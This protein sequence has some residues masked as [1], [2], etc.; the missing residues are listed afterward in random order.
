MAFK[1]NLGTLGLNLSLNDRQFKSAMGGASRMI[2]S[3]GAMAA[4][5]AAAGVGALSAG[6]LYSVHSFAK[7]EQAIMNAV[8][9]SGDGIKAFGQFKAAAMDAAAGSMFSATEAGNALEFLSLAGLSSG[10][11]IAALPGVLQL[12]TAGQIELGQA[13]DIATDTLTA[14]GLTAGDLTRVNDVLVRTFTSSNTSLT[15]LGEAMSYVGP[16]ARSM[17]VDIET[18]AAALGLLGD[19]GIKGSEGGTMLRGVMLRL[20]APTDDA[21]GA[22][23]KLKVSVY[24]TDGTMRDL[25]GVFEDL[26]KATDDLAGEDVNA[27]MRDIFGVRNIAGAE[28]LNQAVRNA[29]KSFRGYRDS[30]YE[31][32]GEGARVERMMESTLS[33]SMKKLKGNVENLAIMFGQFFGPAIYDVATRLGDMIKRVATTDEGFEGMRSAAIHVLRTLAD[34]LDGAAS[35]VEVFGHIVGATLEAIN[36]FDSYTKMIK[37]TAATHD[38]IR[39]VFHGNAM[40][41]ASAYA[42][43]ASAQNVF[44]HSVKK[45]GGTYD[46]ATAGAKLAANGIRVIASASREGANAAAEM[47]HET[48]AQ[49]VVLDKMSKLEGGKKKRIGGAKKATPKDTAMEAAMGILGFGAGVAQ[50]AQKEH[51]AALEAANKA[52]KDDLINALDETLKGIKERAAIEKR[53]QRAAE[54]AAKVRLE[55]EEAHA[56]AYVESGEASADI[57]RHFTDK[58]LGVITS[59]FGPG[60][61]EFVGAMDSA[62]AIGKEVFDQTGSHVAAV[63]AGLADAALS[64]VGAIA[65]TDEFQDGMAAVNH[66]F[67]RLI[68]EVDPLGW[69]ASHLEGAFGAFIIAFEEI[70]EMFPEMGGMSSELAKAF[71]DAA[72]GLIWMMVGV[73]EVLNRISQGFNWLMAAIM[74]IP[75]FLADMINGILDFFGFDKIDTGGIDGVLAGFEEASAAAAAT[76]DKLGQIRDSIGEMTYTDATTAFNDEVTEMADNMSELNDE[77]RNAPSGFKTRLASMRYDAD[78]GV[79]VGSGGGGGSTTVNINALGMRASELIQSL[80]RR[81]ILRS[82]SSTVVESTRYSA[83]YAARRF[84]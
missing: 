29:D 78:D 33:G 53:A 24:D 8:A 34:F 51:A 43:M 72:R 82:G 19:V 75:K 20:A 56:Q 28:A 50:K 58:A 25:V 57:A 4:K 6:L 15:Q 21:R 1:L 70:A 9:V 11:S 61:E 73:G 30:M 47:T 64:L 41:Q 62:F 60:F 12:A 46:K 65:A 54:K 48:L 2:K 16:V 55:A 7:F 13:T 68:G 44:D 63:A 77:L 35:F 3:F 14:F 10:E 17:G 83:D 5:A 22:L 52:V 66:A 36:A 59:I 84:A 42:K 37:L 23:K 27:L 74:Q 76:A 40:E 69:L 81:S 80:E 67:E 39:N 49:Q 38:F 79:A 45:L 26:S 71:F 31:A 18:T 32:R